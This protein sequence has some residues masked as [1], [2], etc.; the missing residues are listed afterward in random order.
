VDI[1]YNQGK[2]GEEGGVQL[3]WREGRRQWAW[4]G[5]HQAPDP[6]VVSRGRLMMKVLD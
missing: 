3:L 6:R 1:R 2:A 4:T 5:G